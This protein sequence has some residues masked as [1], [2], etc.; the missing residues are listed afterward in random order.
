MNRTRLTIAGAAV[1]CLT[2]IA[3]IAATREVWGPDVAGDPAYRSGRKS[4]CRAPE[5]TGSNL[6]LK[7]TDR[8]V[9]VHGRGVEHVLEY[10]FDTGSFA[11]GSIYVCSEY[12]LSGTSWSLRHPR[13]NRDHSQ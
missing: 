5:L 13:T 1:A 9:T 10:T 8:G 11:G 3:W 6:A 4:V 7:A 2:A 12:R